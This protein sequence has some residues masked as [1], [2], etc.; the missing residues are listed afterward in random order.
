M[1]EANLEKLTDISS[2]VR[3]QKVSESF[4]MYA[5]KNRRKLKWTETNGGRELS[6]NK[7]NCQV[8]KRHDKGVSG[9]EEK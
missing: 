5:I 7:K 9:K 2:W 6:E 8:E 1:K 4:E 3:L